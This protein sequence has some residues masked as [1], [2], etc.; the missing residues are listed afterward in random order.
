MT[1]NGNGNLWSRQ[2]RTAKKCNKENYIHT[3][4]NRHRHIY[5]FYIELYIILIIFSLNPLAKWANDMLQCS[6]PTL[7]TTDVFDLWK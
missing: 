7:K 4:I 6:S 5:V 1:R 2:R 3:P